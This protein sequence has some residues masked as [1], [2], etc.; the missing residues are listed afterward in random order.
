MIGSYDQIIS[1][2]RYTVFRLVSIIGGVLSISTSLFYSIVLHGNY[3]LFPVYLS[4]GIIL[5]TNLLLL[6]WHQNN[7]WSYGVAL[8]ISCLTVHLSSWFS[9]GCTSPDLFLFAV[10][11]LGTYLLFNR[12][13]GRIAVLIT[14]GDVLF[15]YLFDEYLPQNTIP[16]DATE[17]NTTLTLIIV[18]ALIGAFAYALDKSKDLALNE[19][20]HSNDELK[21]AAIELEKLSIAISNTDNSIMITN[22]EGK[23]EWVNNGFIKLTGYT[24]AD[25][26]GTT[27][28]ILRKKGRTGFA[29]PGIY[30]RCIDERK[31]L[32]Y[33]EIN[34]NK[35][36]QEYWLATTFTPI[37]N[38][39]GEI[40]NF[41]AIDTDVTERKQMED[42]LRKS[43]DAVEESA[44]NQREFINNVSKEIQAPLHGMITMSNELSA[45]QL[46]DEQ[47]TFVE[48]LRMA[49]NTLNLT[50]D[51]ILDLSKIRIKK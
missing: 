41:I 21:A 36:G 49:A 1:N 6:K 8:T 23:I 13:I 34:V 51:D 7:S 27:G 40:K 25:V 33:T 47:R 29:D 32:N 45:T 28:D 9:G 2:Q 46:D 17:W 22:A 31:S 14:I 20:K 11:I 26:T 4:L 12:F 16:E 15:F 43:K 5:L 3:E 38:E 50:L 35:R 39:Q 44:K 19:L 24:L 18:L 30:Q 42:E 37:F 48:T 10:F